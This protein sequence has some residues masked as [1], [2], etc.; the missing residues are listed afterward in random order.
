[1]DAS[2]QSVSMDCEI[3]TRKVSGDKN[4]EGGGRVSSAER[5]DDE[6]KKHKCVKDD[7]SSFSRV[8]FFSLYYLSFIIG[9]VC[10]RGGAGDDN[11]FFV[12]FNYYYCYYY[13]HHIIINI[14]YR[15]YSYCCIMFGSTRASL[16]YVTS[17]CCGSEHP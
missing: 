1:M 9:E 11:E 7:T 12:V 14:Y 17:M 2:A 15:Y 16:S 8:P 5:G 13:H 10:V 3:E 4:S 6:K